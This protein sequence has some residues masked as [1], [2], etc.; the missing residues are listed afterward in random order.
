MYGFGQ[1]KPLAQ[2][3]GAPESVYDRP[4]NVH[5]THVG[6]GFVA[7][8]LGL[9]VPAASSDDA[10]GLA[11]E[12]ADTMIPTPIQPSTRVFM[13]PPADFDDLPTYTCNVGRC[14]IVTK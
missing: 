4:R 5:V 7:A 2:P 3:C 12:H 8:A 9:P 6:T 1:L 14:S 10:S 11:D 13:A